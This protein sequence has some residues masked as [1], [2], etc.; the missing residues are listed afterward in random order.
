VKKYSL[1]FCFLAI[2]FVVAFISCKRINESTEL[3]GDLIP[4]VDNVKT[5]DTSLT[6][7][8]NNLRFTDSVKVAFSDFVAAG[9]LNDPEFGQTHANF[10]FN[11][12]PSTLGTYPFVSKDSVKIVDSVVLSLAY[13]GSYG[14]TLNGV[15]TLRVFE[16][17]PTSG[18]RFDT[19]YKYNDPAS[20]FATTG[21]EL[22]S[23][24]FNVSKLKDSI[25]ISRP[26]D[27]TKV[28][29]VVRIRLN[30]S[31]ATRFM[32][33][34]TTS[35]PLGG[36]H[37][38]ST[39]GNIFRSLFAGFSIKAD[40]SGNVLSYFTPS[41][42]NT[43]LTV[44]YQVVHSNTPVRDT[45]SYDFF[46]TT[47]GQSNYVKTMPGGNWAALLS[48][49]Q[50]SDDK[51]YLQGSPSGSY[52]SILIPSLPSL[53][54]K[55][56]HR[57][58]IIATRIPSVLDNIFFPPSQLFLDRTNFGTPD[59][60]FV[61]YNDIGLGLDGSIDLSSFGGNLKSNMYRFNITRYV[62]GIV[63]RHE[64]NDTLRLYAPLSTTLFTPTLPTPYVTIPV[65][66]AIGDGR[67]VLAGGSY[68][69]PNVRLRLRIVYSN[70]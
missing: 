67:V 55:V 63:T 7:V 48:N 11:I 27:T 20:E 15:Q 68:P 16:I 28:A 36:Y 42:T 51:I 69:D 46:H 58:E 29:N 24:T 66:S 21:G 64:P 5:F 65:L 8:T 50:L 44:Y 37:S 47:N 1:G 12:L 23:A 9:D 17:A 19:L 52:A 6:A 14:D 26:H 40:N 2:G 25:Q 39:V 45:L 4:G 70:L 13:A 31:L 3:G 61:F 35:G 10:Q 57:A 56:I 53:G 30:S 22:G 41:S 32:Q 34:D 43:K 54:N 62:Q 59:T 49:G 18:F 38:D 33:Y 60:A